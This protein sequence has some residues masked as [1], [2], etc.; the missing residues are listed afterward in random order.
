MAAK[1]VADSGLQKTVCAFDRS[2]VSV[3][4]TNESRAHQRPA[5][6]NAAGEID[7]PAWA[8]E[9]FPEAWISRISR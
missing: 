3:R 5:R 4:K 6:G 1:P 7:V 8:G 9:R 2:A